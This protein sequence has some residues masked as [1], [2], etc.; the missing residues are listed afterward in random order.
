MTEIATWRRPSEEAKKHPLRHITKISI[1]KIKSSSTNHL[2]LNSSRAPHCR[3]A[4]SQSIIRSTQSRRSRGRAACISRGE[5][6]AGTGNEAT[7]FG[8]LRWR[9][10]LSRR[11]GDIVC[12]SRHFSSGE[13]T[14]PD[15]AGL[16]GLS[17]FRHPF[18]IAPAPH[19]LIN[20]VPSS[21]SRTTAAAGTFVGFRVMHDDRKGGKCWGLKMETRESIYGGFELHSCCC[22]E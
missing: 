20:R 15:P 5:V 1:S 13:C 14:E 6:E 21:R 11:G 10:G 2:L 7:E 12:N 4:A 16:P 19:S 3:I 22:R 18:P 8:K 17:D 9:L